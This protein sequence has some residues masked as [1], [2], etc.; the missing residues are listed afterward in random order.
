VAE[1]RGSTAAMG[2]NPP[3]GVGQRSSKLQRREWA[4]EQ[5]WCRVG[6]HGS[7]GAGGRVSS[8][9][10]G[11]WFGHVWFKCGRPGAHNSFG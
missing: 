1:A 4:G 7:G 3:S 2:G 5:Q 10:G 6:T 8:G 9:D 11:V